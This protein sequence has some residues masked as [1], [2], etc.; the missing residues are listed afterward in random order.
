MKATNPETKKLLP[1]FKEMAALVGLDTAGVTVSLSTR[2]KMPYMMGGR[3]FLPTGLSKYT[4]ALSFVH[5]LQ[6]ARD[7]FD[8]IDLPREEMEVRARLTEARFKKLLPSGK[9]ESF[10]EVQREKAAFDEEVRILVEAQARRA[11]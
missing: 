2:N 3:I 11:S 9:G 7:L 6:H 1:W 4:L 8:G 5:E 10:H